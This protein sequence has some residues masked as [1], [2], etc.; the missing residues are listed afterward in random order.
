MLGRDSASLL[1]NLAGVL[2]G[3]TR[4]LLNAGYDSQGVAK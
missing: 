4:V 3:F 2:G 1:L